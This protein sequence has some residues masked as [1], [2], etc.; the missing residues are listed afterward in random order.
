VRPSTSASWYKPPEA[1]YK[2][3]IDDMIK[4]YED[5][6]APYPSK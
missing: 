6:V 3:D 5:V 4:S 2:F 1:L